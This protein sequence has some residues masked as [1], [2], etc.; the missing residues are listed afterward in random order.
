MT[1]TPSPTSIRYSQPTIDRAARAVRCAPFRLKLYAEMITQSVSLGAISVDSGGGAGLSSARH[2]Y[3]TRPLSE[4]AA[5]AELVWLI[6]VGL[7]RRE[8]D[9]QGLTDSFRLT[10]L[11]RQLVHRWQA[12]GRVDFRPSFSDRFYNAVSRWIR[13]PF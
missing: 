6:Q 10:P 7:L 11:G 13:L 9:G 4:L 3:A 2:Q 12:E 8:V 5:E 1:L